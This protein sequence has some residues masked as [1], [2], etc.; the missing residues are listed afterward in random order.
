MTH[1]GYLH[2]T[3]KGWIV[4]YDKNDGVDCY[5]LLHHHD[6][7]TSSF[8]FYNG[9]EVEFEMLTEKFD[10]KNMITYAKL[11]YEVTDPRQ[12][13]TWDNIFDDIESAMDCVVPLKVINYLECHYRKP[14]PLYPEQNQQ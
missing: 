13:N 14:E 11:I 9:K 4:G 6:V 1:K 2:K 3:E 10:G 5:L 7:A 12:C 8:S